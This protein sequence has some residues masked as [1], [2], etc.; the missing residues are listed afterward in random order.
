[1]Q[2]MQYLI[3]EMKFSSAHNSGTWSKT[4]NQHPTMFSKTEC[5]ITTKSYTD[6]LKA[7]IKIMVK[8]FL[9]VIIFFAES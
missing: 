9:E 4:N 5:E 1:M 3:F 7:L 6:I 2:L 8:T